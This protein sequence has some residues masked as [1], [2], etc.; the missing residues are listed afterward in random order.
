MFINLKAVLGTTLMISAIATGFA[1]AGAHTASAADN[2]QTSTAKVSLSLPSDAA[3]GIKSAP[4]LDFG[5]QAVSTQQTTM[6]VA[7]KPEALVVSN[8]GLTSTWSVKVSASNFT[9]AGSTRTIQGAQ[10][11]MGNGAVS[12]ENDNNVSTKPTAA[13][14]VTVD[15]GGSAVDVL[16]S[17]ADGS[18]V[19]NFADAFSADEVQLIV[20]AGNVTGDYAASLTWELS[21]TPD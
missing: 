20:P 7:Q 12:A 15:A 6:K 14:D 11:V 16:S 3:V 4:D 18:S 19:G 5:S 1:F 2:E 13:S 17:A 9:K 8:P 21:S 10:I